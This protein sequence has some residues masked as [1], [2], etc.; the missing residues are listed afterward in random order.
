MKSHNRSRTH[1]TFAAWA[2][3]FSVICSGSVFA[4]D[5]L[6]STQTRL[7]AETMALWGMENESD[8]A[9]LSGL[10]GLLNA[11]VSLDPD[12]PWRADYYANILREQFKDDA[13][14]SAQLSLLLA[15]PRGVF[16]GISRVDAI[17]EPS[18]N[19]RVTVQMAEG[20]TA[21]VEARIKRDGNAADI[22]LIV[23]TLSG[24]IVVSDIGSATGIEGTGALVQWVP[25]TC[26][27]VQ[28]IVTNAGN[29]PARL[30]MMAPPSRQDD[31][32]AVRKQ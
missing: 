23:K 15:R 11:G 4:N 14:L 2:F 12:D 10:S 1:R 9:L 3:A 20:E 18:E 30:V 17:L 26:E 25:E 5:R 28:I 19:M 7:A 13:K 22:D 27:K 32:G 6:V 24:D 16:D 31:C 8:L 21:L 29:V